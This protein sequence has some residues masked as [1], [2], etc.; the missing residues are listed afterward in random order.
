MSSWLSSSH[1]C[2]V[3]RGA[4]RDREIRRAGEVPPHSDLAVGGAT[5]RKVDGRAG[6]FGGRVSSDVALLGFRACRGVPDAFSPVDN[7]LHRTS[8]TG[9]EA[10]PIRVEVAA[11]AGAQVVVFMA[12]TAA[13]QDTV[14]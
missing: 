5:Q 3:R 14:G 10:S 11:L 9:H 1:A 2:R 4:L 13:T 6:S 12:P 7:L 8:K